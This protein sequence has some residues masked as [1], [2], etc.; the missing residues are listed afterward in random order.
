[1]DVAVK[2]RTHGARHGAGVDPGV[3]ALRSC[4]YIYVKKK[5][6]GAASCWAAKTLISL[7]FPI[8]YLTAVNTATSPQQ[9]VAGA[10][11]APTTEDH[12]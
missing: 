1:V 4:I 11:L 9:F 10:A 7:R 12:A 6:R 8:C 2:R 5:D 3:C